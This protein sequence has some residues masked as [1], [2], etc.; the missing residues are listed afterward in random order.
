[1]E[2]IGDVSRFIHVLF[3]AAGLAAFWVPIATRKGATNHVR[4]GK[5]FVWCAYIVL[6]AAA[7]ALSVRI[8][9]MIQLGISPADNSNGWA[10]SVFL[11]YLTFVT[12]V[13]VRHGVGVLR[14]KNDPQGLAS[15]L[16]LILAVLSILASLLVIAYAIVLSP[17][18]KIVLF[19]LSPIGFGTGFGMLQYVRNPPTSARAW[20]Y[21]HLGAML[22]SGIAFHTAFAVF[23]MNRLFEINLGGWFAIVPWI[24][25]AAIGIP[26]ITIW[27]RH[28]R[29]KFGEL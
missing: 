16:T 17:E 2:I 18:I 27:T 1:M 23:G 7:I 9:T 8:A 12:F 4:F 15:R 26:A 13:N 25:P 29:R 10:S 19:A 28:Y 6:G 24:L 14:Y 21:E 3:G 11:A 20:M 5:I 22:G